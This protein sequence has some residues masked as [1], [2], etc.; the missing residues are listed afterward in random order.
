MHQWKA[1]ITFY[2][3]ARGLRIWEG[4]V[5]AADAAE[6]DERA[7]HAFRLSRRRLHVPKIV[8]VRLRRVKGSPTT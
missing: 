2:T 8:E 7:I 4:Q 3:P 5:E 6:A 1:R